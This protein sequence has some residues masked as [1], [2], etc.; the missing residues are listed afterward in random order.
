MFGFVFIDAPCPDPITASRVE[1]YGTLAVNGALHAGTG[2]MQLQHIQH[3]DPR[4]TRLDL[5]FLRAV[6][7]PGSWRDF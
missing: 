6:P 7:V 3:A 1:I 2:A 5:P 4:M